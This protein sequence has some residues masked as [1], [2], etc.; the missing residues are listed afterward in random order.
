MA[1]EEEFGSDDSPL[2]ISDEDAESHHPPSKPPSTTSRHRAQATSPASRHSKRNLLHTGGPE[3]G[4]ARFL[5]RRRGLTQ[6]LHWLEFT[7]TIIP[8]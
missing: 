7:F 4:S 3:C 2:E 5:R 6:G 1:F 8:A